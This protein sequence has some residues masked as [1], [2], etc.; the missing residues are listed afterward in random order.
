MKD[1]TVLACDVG[2]TRLRAALVRLD[3]TVVAKRVVPTPPDDPGALPR[4]MRVMLD[5]SEGA[6][7][8]AVVGL[9]GPIDYSL[10][11]ALRLP[12]LPDWQG[13]VSAHGLSHELSFTVLL[14]NDADLAALGEHRY[15]AG[16]TARDMLYITASTGIGA[17]VIIGGRL[18]KGRQS[19][20][21][22]GHTIIE[23]SSHS[24]VESLG[25]GT[26]LARL[27]GDDAASVAARATARDAEALQLFATVAEA[28]ATGVFNSVHSFSP[29]I[30][31]IGGGMSKA[32]DLLLDPVRE[33]LTGCGEEC[34]AARVKVVG[35]HGDDDVG[36]KGAA[37]YWI[38]SSLR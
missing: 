29:E 17:G 10:G 13:A 19:L 38:D 25:S 14:A 27:A 8:G 4:L 21:E 3:G 30:V 6:V 11:E 32:G 26:A 36:L 18:L 16:V 2:G 33:M 5:E 37:A 15:G 34:P 22:V 1:K 9:P 20:A 28:F 35:A 31:V 7:V 23:R 12:N 24:T